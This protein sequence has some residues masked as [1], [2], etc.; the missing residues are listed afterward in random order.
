MAARKK[1]TEDK[2]KPAQPEELTEKLLQ[3]YE[4]GKEEGRQIGQQEVYVGITDF[5]SQRMISHFSL[6]NDEMAKELREIYL[7]IKKNVQQ[8]P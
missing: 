2:L 7:L 1:Q 6:K 8:N 5:L 3:S 4:R